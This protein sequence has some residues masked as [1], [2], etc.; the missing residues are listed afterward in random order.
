MKKLAAMFPLVMLLV[1]CSCASSRMKA[2]DRW[3]YAPCRAL[4]AVGDTA[5]VGH[6]GVVARV[7]YGREA[8]LQKEVLTDGRISDIDIHGNRVYVAN[9]KHGLQVFD[10][11]L[12]LISET[13]EP[14][15][16]RKLAAGDD[17][18]VVSVGKGGLWVLDGK[19]L[20][21]K[22]SLETEGAI[23]NRLIL[24]D[25]KLILLSS[26][27]STPKKGPVLAVIS[28]SSEGE[29]LTRARL[30][31]PEGRWR[32]FNLAGD[33]LYVARQILESANNL[34]GELAAKQ[35]PGEFL[36]DMFHMSA[37]IPN[38]PARTYGPFDGV[39]GQILVRDDLLYMSNMN[40]LSVYSLEEPS[41]KWRREYV[42]GTGPLAATE[43][44]VFVNS[45]SHDP[46]GVRTIELLSNGQIGEIANFEVPH[47]M[48]GVFIK[49]GL[50]YA[51][52]CRD[53]LRIFD[54][55]DPKEMKLLSWL[56]LPT[57]SEDAW[58]TGTEVYVA[59]GMGI[60][61]ID[62][63]D[64]RNPRIDKYIDDYPHQMVHWVEGVRRAGDYLYVAAHSRLRIIDVADPKNAHQVSELAIRT[65]KDLVVRDG[66]CHIAE[67]P[68]YTIVDVNDPKA[69]FEVSFTPFAGKPHAKGFDIELKDNYAF[70]SCE[71]DGVYVFDFSDAKE[72]KLVN[73][74]HTEK[75][76]FQGVEIYEDYLYVCT[77]YEQ[78]VLK[79]DISDPRNPALVGGLDTPAAA[80]NIKIREGLFAIADYKGGIIIGK[81]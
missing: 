79:Y 46:H 68:G 73:V 45:R 43:E 35:G 37:E 32:D 8:E 23:G 66:L 40:D 7:K 59:D 57:L 48:E 39:V 29:M 72:P 2:L 75:N 6:G 41:K 3:P 56:D 11:D 62:A 69:P 54:I 30:E 14:Y 4:D 21:K 31:C 58:V 36:V 80:L 50:L 5:Y 10:P 1:C 81:P 49:D 60:A 20:E 53:G 55:S 63:S 71:R 47:D 16:I 42:Q 28:F 76:G 78:G 34:P 67:N 13:A 51:A 74:V 38:I 64:P 52:C 26:S 24:A 33:R 27:P 61:I 22:S 12:I 19:T 17:F 70:V 9:W 18:I 77:V 25:K 65:G 44:H 15:N